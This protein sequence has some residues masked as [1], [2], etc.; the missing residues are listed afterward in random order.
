MALDYCSGKDMALHLANHGVF[1][2]EMAKFYISELILA[3]EYLHSLD[4]IY[5]DLK[6]ENIL[7]DQDGHIK[8]ADF[9]LSKEGV[10]DNETTKSFCGSPIYLCPEMLRN[11]G[12]SKM[13]DI[14]G[15]GLVLYEMVAGNPPFYSDEIQIVYRMIMN[16]K[17]QYPRSLSKVV[18]SLLEVKLSFLKIIIIIFS[19]SL[20][21]KNP[22]KRPTIKEIKEHE[23]FRNLDWEGVFRKEYEPP[24]LDNETC[25][26]L[27]ADK[28]TLIKYFCLFFSNSI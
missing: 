5:R 21:Q 12:F 26:P 27:K 15:I 1:S 19:K 9:G 23:F 25:I 18:V 24:F 11:K 28:V 2:E 20:L 10:K 17:V 6:P 14:Y 7:L 13:S 8:L 22:E 16:G 3:V 4:I